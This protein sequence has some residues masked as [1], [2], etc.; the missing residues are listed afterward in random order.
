[1]TMDPRWI[2]ALLLMLVHSLMVALEARLDCPEAAAQAISVLV[3]L[4]LFADAIAGE[5]YFS[6]TVSTQFLSVLVVLEL[7][8][9]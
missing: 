3:P 1:M 6:P 5:L 4:P 7:A 8:Q 9:A 2:R